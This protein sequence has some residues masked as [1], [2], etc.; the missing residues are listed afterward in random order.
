LWFRYFKNYYNQTRKA[1]A[2]IPEGPHSAKAVTYMLDVFKLPNRIAAPGYSN[3]QGGIAVDFQQNRAKGSEISNSYEP[4][5]QKKWRA[6][7]FFDW[8]KKNCARFGF[9]QYI[10]EAWHW[11]HRPIASGVETSRAGGLFKEFEFESEQSARP[12]LGGFVR[13]F[14]SKGL[15]VTVS[16]FCPRA[17][18]SR[19][20]VEV[21]VYAHGL[22]NPCPPVPKRLPEGFIT[23][24]PFRLGQIVDASNRGIILVVPF[25]DWKPRQRHALG[26]PGN[27]NR[28]VDEVLAEVGAIQGT[29][30]PSLSGLIL[31][32]HSRAY[33]FLEPLASSYTDPQ[34]QQGSLAKLTQVWAFDTTYACDVNAWMGWLTSKPNLQVSV[35]FRKT[36]L[37]DKSG[38]ANC[39]WRL[40]SNIKAS[41][42]RLRVIP[43]DPA[44]KHCEV[45]VRR[46]AGLLSASSRSGLRGIR[47]FR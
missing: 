25:F 30:P 20:S 28:L 27:L 2:G 26:R 17:A 21:L 19:G 42:G 3:H 40:Y 34:M 47:T 44:E 12:Y 16:V 13:T 33:D 43:L 37:G 23:A 31:A 45:P 7:W 4:N 29:A 11:E 5:E 38:T 32:G 18:M 15:P 24:A 10:K 6:S 9:R 46:L 36:V 22:L 14:A 35:F 8:L 1:R 41:G 39:G